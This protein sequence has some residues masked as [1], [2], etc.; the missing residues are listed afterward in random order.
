MASWTSRA[1]GNSRCRLH[2]LGTLIDF[3]TEQRTCQD[4]EFWNSPSWFFG[5]P[6]P[7]F[8]VWSTISNSPC[9]LRVLSRSSW[10]RPLPQ[11]V[12]L[13]SELL[14]I[15]WRPVLATRLPIS[16]RHLPLLPLTYLLLGKPVM[17]ME[18]TWKVWPWPW[19]IKLV[20]QAPNLYN[21]EHQN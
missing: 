19:S 2:S 18:M 8:S 13:E 1:A 10:W 20:R 17:F 11:P 6:P 3:I 7:N 12:E 15:H 4:L 21:R 5:A 16:K 9:S 14:L